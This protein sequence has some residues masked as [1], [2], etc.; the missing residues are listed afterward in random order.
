VFQERQNEVERLGTHA[1]VA[2]QER[3]GPEHEQRAHDLVVDGSADAAGVRPDEVDLKLRELRGLDLD[4]GEQP[5]AR[6]DAVDFVFAGEDLLDGAAEAHE[7]VFRLR[8]DRHLRI[9]SPGESNQLVRRQPV[10]PEFEGSRHERRA[11]IAAA[12]SVAP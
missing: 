6:I 1:A 10:F 8:R 3:M 5:E 11:L 12:R 7:A 9:G 2:Y 4:V